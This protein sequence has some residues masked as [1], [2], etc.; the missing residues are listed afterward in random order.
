VAYGRVNRADRALLDDALR[1]LDALS[2]KIAPEV[3]SAIRGLN[4]KQWVYLKDARR[5][6][7]FVDPSGDAAYAVLGLTQG[8]R[9]I[10]GKPGAMI[11]TGLTVYGGHYVCDCVITR[12]V[13]LGPGYR[14]S[15]SE[16]FA[17]IKTR[18]AFRTT[19]ESL[20]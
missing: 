12:I 1:D 14:K 15:F 19:G 7:I 5:H 6:S 20:R 16:A 3:V 9:E 4:V 8:M 10:L 17:G 11:E 13:W 18:G 2:V